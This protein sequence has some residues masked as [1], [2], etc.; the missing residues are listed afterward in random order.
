MTAWLAGR[1][2]A[3][4][5]RQLS[6]A[7]IRQ[8]P[9]KRA[10]DVVLAALLLIVLSPVMLLAY[11]AVR[12]TSP[13]GAVFRQVRVGAGTQ[14]FVLLKFRTMVQD[15]SHEAHQSFVR[16]MMAGEDPRQY[17][18][19]YKLDH[20]PRVTPVGRFLRRTSID[21]LPQLINVLRGDMSLVGPRPALPWE[22]ELFPISVSSRFLVRPGLTGLWQ[23]SGRNRLT[24]LDG[25]RLDV[26]YVE[27]CAPATDLR[28]IVF[29]PLTMLRGGAR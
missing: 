28:I 1:L 5:T 2:S 20:D 21:E 10:L 8:Y 3:R 11:V 12:I 25:L 7:G 14:P 4:R 9:G 6:R 17:E 23:I 29:T 27:K 13:G 16:R 19:L 15:C 26:E 24:M 18:G 22:A